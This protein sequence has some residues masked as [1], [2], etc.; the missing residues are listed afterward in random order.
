M[1]TQLSLALSALLLMSCAFASQ[2]MPGGGGGAALIADTPTL[3]PTEYVLTQPAPTETAAS[4]LPAP[5]ALPS[6]TAPGGVLSG[7]AFH[8]QD[9]DGL[10]SETEPGVPG[11]K[12]CLGSIGGPFCATTDQEGVY[13]LANLPIGAGQILLQP[14]PDRPHAQAFRYLNRFLAWETLPGYPVDVHWA[15]EQ[16][17]PRTSLQTIDKPIPVEITAAPS[18]LE[19]PL[20]QGYLTDVFRCGD[21]QRLNILDFQAFDLDPAQGSVRHYYESE[22][23]TFENDQVVMFGDNHFAIDWGNTNT[24]II[25][26]PLYAPANGKVVFAGLGSTWNGMCNVVNLVHPETG[27]SSGVVHLDTV[28]VQERQEVLRGQLLGTLGMSCTTW[29]HV[30]LYFKPG[31]DRTTNAWDGHDP[32]RDSADPASQTYWTTDNQP[33]CPAFLGSV[34]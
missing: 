17:L 1:H 14:D 9:G 18:S 15:P 2:I 22:A 19:L 12:V 11:L 13:A 29:P 3:P 6:P 20:T 32:Y 10:R 27:D 25:G 24:N 28:L 4:T 33:H 34:P 26:T 16:T 23:R 8:D 31:W 30:H 7:F 21:R 5:T